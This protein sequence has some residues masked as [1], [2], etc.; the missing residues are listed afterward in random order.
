MIRQKVEELKQGILELERL[1]ESLSGRVEPP[2]DWLI[3]RIFVWYE[4]YVRGGVV[5]REELHEIAGKYG[6]DPR[7]LGGFFAGDEPS[8]RYI[9]GRSKV[10][11]QD[12]AVEY[13]E[14]FKNWIEEHKDEY[15]RQAG[16]S[17]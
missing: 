1:L 12:W 14:R 7:G 16:G 5:S 9:M 10:V 6:Y 8:L 17:R 11:L 15:A 3:P 4:I 2:E 13:V